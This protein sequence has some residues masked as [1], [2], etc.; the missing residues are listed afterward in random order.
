MLRNR[1]LRVCVW[2]Q[3]TEMEGGTPRVTRS[4]VVMHR[5]LGPEG[6]WQEHKKWVEG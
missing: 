5:M 4:V 6:K 2:V 3:S 1:M